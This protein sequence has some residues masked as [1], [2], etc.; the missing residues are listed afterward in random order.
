M[1]GP[2][3]RL[4]VDV[5]NLA[6]KCESLDVDPD[7]TVLDL[8]YTVAELWKAPLK[9]LKFLSGAEILPDDVKLGTMP[10]DG[11]GKLVV[12]VVVS[13]DGLFAKLSSKIP[14]QRCIALRTLLALAPNRDVAISKALQCLED[15]SHLVRTAALQ[16]F[17]VQERGHL[18]ALDGAI[19][20][21]AD[22]CTAVRIAAVAAV[23]LLAPD[24][25]V[26]L[27]ASL[28]LCECLHDSDQH[29]RSSVLAVL[30]RLC[31]GGDDEGSVT[32]AMIG[33]ARA[34]LDSPYGPKRVT[35]VEVLAKVAAFGGEPMFD[36]VKPCF[37]DRHSPVRRVAVETSGQFVP[38][39]DPDGITVLRERIHDHHP[40][41][42][43]AAFKA[44]QTMVICADAPLVNE[45]IECIADTTSS[46]QMT[47]DAMETLAIVAKT[48]GSAGPASS[49]VVAAFA[50]PLE[51]KSPNVRDVAATVIAEVAGRGDAD[52]VQIALNCLGHVKADVRLAGALALG[53][54]APIGDA[55]ASEA[56]GVLLEDPHVSL[57][58]AGID[59]LTQVIGPQGDAF[60]GLPAVL[61]TRLAHPKA[62]VRC[63]A[64]QVA[65]KVV[66]RGDVDAQSQLEV[67]LADADIGVRQAAETVLAAARTQ[68]EACAS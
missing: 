59:A 60:V 45:I 13:L 64:L 67:V 36:L 20:R 24:N 51:H 30:L 34:L 29:V 46:E 44:L 15:P 65:A 31:R 49:L 8:K 48:T 41:V 7:D 54:V 27:D 4:R 52:A 68:V 25:E 47:I 33:V 37:T 21:L 6:G 62:A 40:M 66:R 35:G 58:N 39:G 19:L 23:A 53:R 17:D 2:S 26:G 16:V 57:R 38:A 3:A 14:Q 50:A 61:S 10:C 1:E 42:Q 18:P 43:R 9:G 22:P 55:R 5:T 12:M 28:R 63:A 11:Q 56:L 32:R